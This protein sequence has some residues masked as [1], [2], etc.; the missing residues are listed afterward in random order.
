M[1]MGFA[2]TL[3]GAGRGGTGRRIPPKGSF[4]DGVERRLG[5]ALHEAECEVELG[6]DV[7]AFVAGQCERQAYVSNSRFRES[8]MIFTSSKQAAREA[9]MR[10]A[11]RKLVLEMATLATP[12]DEAPRASLRV[13]PGFRPRMAATVAG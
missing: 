2:A 1:R 9:M 3:I 7:L 8:Q 12:E 4:E 6:A 11:D 10:P 5:R 13:R